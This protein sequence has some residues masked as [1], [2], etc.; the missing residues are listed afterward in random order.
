MKLRYVALAGAALL[1]GMWWYYRQARRRK[2]VQGAYTAFGS[3]G[4]LP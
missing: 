1:V 2:V 4:F 3:L